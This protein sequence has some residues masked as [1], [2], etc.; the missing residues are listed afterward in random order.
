MEY[1]C[2]AFYAR[3]RF[4]SEDPNPGSKATPSLSIFYGSALSLI[5]SGEF[6][7]GKIFTGRDQRSFLFAPLQDLLFHFRRPDCSFFRDL[8]CI[9]SAIDCLYSNSSKRD[10]LHFFVAILSFFLDGRKKK[11]RGLDFVCTCGIFSRGGKSLPGN[12]VA[13]LNS[14]FFVS[15]SYKRRTPSFF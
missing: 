8:G 5:W 9:V 6:F 7:G 3:G 11:K 14:H 15:N 2:S 1:R 10:S 13:F 12:S 4:S